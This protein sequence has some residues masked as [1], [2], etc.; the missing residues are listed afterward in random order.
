MEGDLHY[1]FTIP[2]NWFFH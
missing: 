2:E 1:Y